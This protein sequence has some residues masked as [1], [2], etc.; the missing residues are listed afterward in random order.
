MTAFF[1]LRS[2]PSAV[3]LQ[4]MALPEALIDVSL[5]SHAMGLPGGEFESA[6]SNV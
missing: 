1:A 2:L 6:A 4:A 5:V 3:S